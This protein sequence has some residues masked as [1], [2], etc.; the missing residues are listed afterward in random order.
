MQTRAIKTA[1]I[2]MNL[3]AACL[4]IVLGIITMSMSFITR[5]CCV[6]GFLLVVA[7]L[8]LSYLYAAPVRKAFKMVGFDLTGVPGILAAFG[9]AYN[10]ILIE[11][12]R[13]C[14]TSITLLCQYVSFRHDD[15]SFVLKHDNDGELYTLRTLLTT[16]ASSPLSYLSLRRSS[17][18]LLSLAHPSI[19]LYTSSS[20][21][22]SLSISSPRLTLRATAPSSPEK[23]SNPQKNRKT[24]H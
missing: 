24:I 23:Q 7:G 20:T 5:S 2:F 3:A 10:T 9:V 18:R 11:L 13:N 22:R 21:V 1:T 8:G 4:L 15:D 12:T 14:S 6:S 17:S 16:A 19:S